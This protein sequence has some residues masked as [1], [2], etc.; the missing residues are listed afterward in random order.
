MPINWFANDVGS[1]LVRIFQVLFPI[2]WDTWKYPPLFWVLAAGIYVLVSIFHKKSVIDKS[3]T[4][5][6]TLES[7]TESTLESKIESRTN[8]LIGLG[9]EIL[10]GFLLGFWLSPILI[11]TSLRLLVKAAGKYREV[12]QKVALPGKIVGITSFTLVGV[13]IAG[14]AGLSTW[15]WL[16]YSW[17]MG[18][19]F[20]LGLGLI[21]IELAIRVVLRTKKFPFIKDITP[22]KG[23]TL[24]ESPKMMG[25]LFLIFIMLGSAFFMGFFLPPQRNLAGDQTGLAPIDLTMMTYNIRN[26]GATERDPLDNWENRRDDLAAYITTLDVDI[27][28]VQEAYLSQLTYLKQSVSSRQYRF[29]GVGRK[30]G[31]HSGEHAAIFYDSGRFALLEGDDFWLADT[32]RVPSKQWDGDNYRICTWARFQETITGREFY[33]FNT[34]LSTKNVTEAGN[35]HLMSVALLHERIRTFSS[36]LPVFLMGD[37]NLENTSLA[38]GELLSYSEKPLQD[39]FAVANENE[40]GG[41]P[42]DYSTNEFDTTQIPTKSHID[43]IFVSAGISV[44]QCWIPKEVYAGTHP[45]SDHYPVLL[46][47]TIS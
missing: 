28:G 15:L 46:T 12:Y 5:K 39:A 14:I 43:F 32:P 8:L 23:V 9:Y 29:F 20:L 40:T 21:G 19:P 31:V 24:R 7:R 2:G 16:R 30:D 33:V 35:V 44:D 1:W 27:F 10:P 47:A 4:A 11:W 6:S 13:I 3:T 38:Y 42:W 22:F 41:I 25:G 17:T 36:D 34:H 45:Y 37:F 18:L 26:A